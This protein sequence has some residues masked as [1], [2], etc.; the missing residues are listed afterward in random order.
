MAKE[1]HKYFTNV[2]LSLASKIESTSKTFENLLFPIE[3][4]ME[5]GDLAFK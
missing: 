1:F 5:Y 3:K 2:R 4:N